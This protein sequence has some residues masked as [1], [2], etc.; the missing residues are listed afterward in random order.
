M[1]KF[2]PTSD[3]IFKWS[4]NKSFGKIIYFYQHYQDLYDEMRRLISNIEFIQSIDFEL[5]D[6]LPNDGTNYLLIFDDS[7]S[8]LSK[9]QKFDKLAT[10]GRHRGL[11]CIY[12]EH[13]LFHKSAIGRDAEL[14]NI[15]LVLLKSTRDVQQIDRLSTQLGLCKQLVNW[16]KDATTFGHFLIDLSPRTNDNLRYCSD[17]ASFPAV[18]YLPTIKARETEL[19]DVDTE[20]L[21]SQALS[22]LQTKLPEEFYFQFAKGFYSVP[23]RLSSKHVKKRTRGIKS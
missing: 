7:C 9:S 3:R 23:T 13:N 6:N 20:H 10:A 16:Y 15:H 18:F 17:S 11:N 1:N 22:K 2:F 19:K 5:F 21:Y 14:Q 4:K 8:E 12:I